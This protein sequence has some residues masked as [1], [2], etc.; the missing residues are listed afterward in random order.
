VRRALR[1]RSAA[2]PRL[3]G[4]R[5]RPLHRAPLRL[6]GDT[7]V[8]DYPRR[9]IELWP[10]RIELYAELLAAGSRHRLVH[11]ANP[12]AVHAQLAVRCV[13]QLVFKPSAQRE[14]LRG[15]EHVYAA[16]RTLEV[17]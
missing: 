3:S 8:I 12:A 9:K 2:A 16:V 10:A 7:D 6:E 14:P 13:E 11:V 17:E 5:E 15:Q 1:H 4:E